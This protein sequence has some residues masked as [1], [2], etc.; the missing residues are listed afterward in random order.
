MS[1][2]W[3]RIDDVKNRLAGMRIY[4]EAH[5]EK[6]ARAG[7]RRHVERLANDFNEMVDD[8]LYQE[9][10]KPANQQTGKTVGE[11]SD[12]EIQGALSDGVVNF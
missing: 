2:D 11:M 9:T 6:L 12:D 7:T 10:S 5:P 4:L 3:N 8:L 1:F